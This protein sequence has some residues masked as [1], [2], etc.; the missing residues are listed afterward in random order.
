MKQTFQDSVVILRQREKEHTDK[1]NQ[2]LS[3]AAL[4]VAPAFEKLLSDSLE[5]VYA[6]LSLEMQH[7]HDSTYRASMQLR[8]LEGN[9]E[10]LRHDMQA[11]VGNVQQAN[12]AVEGGLQITLMTHEKQLQVA[13]AA[14]GI[15]SALNSLV[16]KAQTEIQSINGTA[17]IMKESLLRDI[18]DDGRFLHWSWFHAALIYC[19]KFISRADPDDL[20]LPA[21]RVVF[22]IARLVWSLLGVAS[23]GLM[24][25]LVLLA[26][27][28]RLFPADR[29]SA[30]PDGRLHSDAHSG[31]L[32]HL[33]LA[34]GGSAS[35][36]SMPDISP[37]WNFELRSAAADHRQRRPRTRFSRI[38]DRLYR[39][40]SGV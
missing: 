29:S 15:A 3:T 36:C 35:D 32:R 23:S 39:P 7:I 40:S 22:A 4:S 30:S 20:E 21:F 2:K 16:E 34:T 1:L 38:P 14:D 26:S 31:R 8:D 9:V 11:L 37:Y 19:F 13:H 17:T 18:S 5:T 6:S 24:S 10:T 27:K 12:H 33:G 28:K 25:V